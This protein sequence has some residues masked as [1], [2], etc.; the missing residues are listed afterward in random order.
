MRTSAMT[1]ETVKRATLQNKP[2]EVMGLPFYGITMDRY[3]EWQ[4]D[5]SVLLARQSTLPV[6]CLTMP[7]IDALFTL[8]LAALEETS[9]LAGTMG[10]ILRVMALSLRL[11]E[12]SVKN[13][14]IALVTH[15]MELKGFSVMMPD[16]MQQFIPKEQFPQIRQIIA[17]Q[18]GEDVP[19]ESLNDELL[20]DEK[21]IAQRNAANLELDFDSLL[22]S[23][24]L[25]AR[26]RIADIY[27]MSILEF[28]MLRRAIDRDK[29]YM[30]CGIAEN[31]GT[32]WKGGNPCP[33]WC[34]DRKQADSS[35]LTHVSKFEGI[36]QR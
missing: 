16:G 2:I 34:Y 11:P 21:W 33:S 22:S 5:K 15:N 14:Q 20:E 36:A 12:D 26:L 25:N 8:D 18:Q 31:N 28:E 24:S 6:F 30:I 9:K 1:Q 3:E 32:K 19:D 10:H 17:W 35:T 29:R 7:F 27:G 4:S 23:V 13:R